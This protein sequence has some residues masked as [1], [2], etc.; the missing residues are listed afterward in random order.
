MGKDVKRCKYCDKVLHDTSRTACSHCYEKIPLVKKLLNMKLPY[1]EEPTTEQS[2]C[3]YCVDG[4][5]ANA[6]GQ[7]YGEYCRVNGLCENGKRGA[8][9]G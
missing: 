9:N 4:M 3:V 5:C 7:M 1:E 6:Y 8:G 2:E